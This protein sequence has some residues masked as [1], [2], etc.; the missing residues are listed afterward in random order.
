[1]PDV[2]DRIDETELATIAKDST[3]GL[4]R[5]SGPP[6]GGPVLAE[7]TATLSPTRLIP[8]FVPRFHFPGPL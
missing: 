5:E 6:A 4:T 8:R 2:S 7:R 3:I 1:M